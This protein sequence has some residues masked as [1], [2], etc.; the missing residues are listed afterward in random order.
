MWLERLDLKRLHKIHTGP[1]ALYDAFVKAIGGNFSKDSLRQAM[2][3]NLLNVSPTGRFTSH[4]FKFKEQC[5]E[6]GNDKG[7]NPDMAL[8]I[9]E[10][11]FNSGKLKTPEILELIRT[12][13]VEVDIYFP[14]VNR[15]YSFKTTDTYSRKR[16]Q[17]CSMG[18]PYDK[19]FSVLIPFK[20]NQVEVIYNTPAKWSKSEYGRR[21]KPRQ[22]HMY[23]YFSGTPK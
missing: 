20:A 22:S 13:G 19:N 14:H 17:I 21:Q 3:F 4:A 23:T 18:F 16:I 9:H 15:F 6:A 7:G 1:Q 12:C 5:L 8:R 10:F 11:I 2:T